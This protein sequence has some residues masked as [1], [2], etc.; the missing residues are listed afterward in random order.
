MKVHKYTDTI[1]SRC[2][3]NRS[4][5]KKEV[6]KQRRKPA[7]RGKWGLQSVQSINLRISPSNTTFPLSFIAAT[8]R[9]TS[10]VS[11]S[12][13]LSGGMAALRYASNAEMDMSSV[14]S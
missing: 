5:R 7:P 9:T 14:V 11:K 1:K 3:K 2:W 10:V 4:I 8:A 6:S 12:S 13:C